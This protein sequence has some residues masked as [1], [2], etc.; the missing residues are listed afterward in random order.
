MIVPKVNMRQ[1][2]K[3]LTI[4][5]PIGGLNGRDGLADMPPKDAFV[6]DNWIPGT[7]TCDARG[8]HSEFV[9]VVHGPGGPIESL[10]AYVGGAVAS[11]KLLAFGN[12]KILDVTTGTP[13]AALATGRTS[14]QVVTT[15]FSNAGSQ[16]LIG[17]SGADLPFSY[18]GTV[19]APLTITG[20]T[21]SPANL[22]HVF[23]FK[24][25]LYFCQKDQLGFYYLVVGAIQGAASYFDLSQVARKGGYLMAMSSF[26]A[27]SG[28]GPADYA[29]FI[30]SEGEYI[31]YS[32]TDP[33]NAATWALV[34]RYYSAPPIGRRCAFSYGSELVI[35]TLGG[36]LPFSAIR[37]EG[38]VS[39]DDAITYKL[40]KYVQE[41]NVNAS[42]HGWQ[43]ALYPKGGLLFINVPAAA[44]V[45]GAYVQFVQ[46][47]VTKAWTR[48]TNLNGICWCEFN[49]DMYFGKYDGRVMKYDTGQFDDGGPILLDCKQAY[50]YFEDG[51]G[52]TN[53]NKHFHFAKLL[54][55]CDGDPPLN[56]Q[57]NVDYVEEQPEYVAGS[58]DTTGFAWDVSSWD[59]SS[60]G[61]D[62]STRFFMV[63]MGKFGVAGS[64]WVRASLN[65][66]TL[67]W[68]ATQYYFSKAQGLF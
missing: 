66:L 11:K 32:G 60:W 49:G 62:L 38:G 12:G 36:A 46:N 48:F 61:G 6:L 22:S 41:K 51:T 1:T 16:F 27:D 63:S 23:A 8:G 67:K 5:P 2:A 24:G 57:F 50:N 33:S 18:E 9:S 25:R 35:L 45:A 52:T 28:N 21:G 15:M 40:G 44:S 19:I 64:L 65:G 53:L 4:P 13:P 59:V 34:G 20:L 30:T 54:L 43:A 10:A 29:V 3:T 7:A 17:V 26:S 47:T 68:Y 58:P 14:N 37:R 55:A 42:V 31:V 39:N 56:A